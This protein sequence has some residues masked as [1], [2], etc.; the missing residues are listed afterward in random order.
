MRVSRLTRVDSGISNQEAF[1]KLKEGKG[2][3]DGKAKL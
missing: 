2:E 3:K 1:S